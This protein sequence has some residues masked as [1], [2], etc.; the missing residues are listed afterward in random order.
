MSSMIVR[1]C[2]GKNLIGFRFILK[3][4]IRIFGGIRNVFLGEGTTDGA[5][6]GRRFGG[7]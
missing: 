5:G 4:V 7:G 1:S 6:M 2:L 3:G